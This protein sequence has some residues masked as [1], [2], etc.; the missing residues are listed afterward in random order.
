M[1]ELRSKQTT[2]RE[3]S[4]QPQPVLYAQASYL[5]ATL[6]LRKA[7]SKAESPG[8]QRGMSYM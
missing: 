8:G 3:L 2:V 1:R 5:K 7:V 4:Q 6:A